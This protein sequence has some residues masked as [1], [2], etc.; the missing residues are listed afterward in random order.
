MSKSGYERA[1]RMKW[2]RTSGLA[3]KRRRTLPGR[4]QKGFALIE[5][6]VAVAIFGVV[7]VSFL[8][9]MVAAYHG[10]LVAHDQTMAQSLVSTALENVRSAAYPL[11][12]SSDNVSTI[13]NYE[14]VIHADNVT[15]TYQITNNASNTQLI[16]VTVRYAASQRT[17]F[18]VTNL[19]VKP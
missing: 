4:G 6:L 7:S 19:K 14:V 1:A 2:S 17:I 13:S 9:A 12:T 8:T 15:T 3:G 5:L 10:A 11:A 18:S 16:T